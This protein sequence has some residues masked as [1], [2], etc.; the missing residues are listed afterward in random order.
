MRLSPPTPAR[1]GTTQPLS[2]FGVDRGAGGGGGGVP[3]N[4]VL[5]KV[6]EV[7]QRH[8]PTYLPSGWTLSLS[9]SLSLA[10][11]LSGSH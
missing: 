7:K 10:P 5:I 9:L 3:F 11:L 8:S 2:Q 1:Q 4:L 6:Q